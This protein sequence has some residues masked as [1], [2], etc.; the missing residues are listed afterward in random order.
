MTNLAASRA[1]HEPLVMAM[2][3]K[4]EAAIE[5]EIGKDDGREMPQVDGI[6]WSMDRVDL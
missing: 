1:A 2:N 5:A 6:S 3:A 4:L